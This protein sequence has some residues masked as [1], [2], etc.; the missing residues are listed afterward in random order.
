MPSKTR[1]CFIL[2]H[3]PQGGAERQ[4]I[5]LLKALDY[6]RYEV[7]LVLYANTELF[8]KEVLD[9]PIQ[10]L[11]HQSPSFS[12]VLRNISNVIYLRK[13]LV[14]NDF[15]ILH[16][17]LFH[18]GFWVRMVAPRRYDQRIIYSVRND[19]Q[20]G[21]R[22]YVFF[23]KLLIRRSMAITNSLKARDQLKALVGE[24][25]LHKIFNIYNGF[26]L[27]R[28]N[29]DVP[30]EIGKEIIIGTV[31]RQTFQKKQI[32][33]LQAV[34]QLY[35]KYFLHFFLI[36]D[37]T[38]DQ[39]YINQNYVEGNRL[40]KWVTILDSQ[41]DIE[42][43]YRRFNIFVLASVYE[44][45]PN[46]L[47]EAMLSRCLCIVSA[48]A[49]SDNFIH[50]GINGLVYDG[51]TSG[52]VKKLETAIALLKSGGS[53]KIVESGNRY[54]HDN[55]ALSQ[56]VSRYEAAYDDIMNKRSICNG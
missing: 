53:V 42:I 45:C 37:K 25:Y 40:E 23:E 9:L 49:N 7:T 35:E 50:D 12:K 38:K 41:A 52:L 26:D 44:G 30:P 32:Q 48:G 43:F 33:I 56:M 4:T 15:D 24:K 16:T 5:N 17:L 21:S 36:G 10:I 22:F 31:G 34:K 28:F 14:R 6:S 20:D 19:L 8:Y 3:L 46:V 51:S 1:I 54:V 47:F 39:S 2:S 18:N 27:K 13:V 11:I 29:S 55:F